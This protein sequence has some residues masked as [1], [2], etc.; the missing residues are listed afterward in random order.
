MDERPA[1]DTGWEMI[2]NEHLELNAGFA[3]DPGTSAYE[4]LHCIC[5]SKY[6][7]TGRLNALFF[8]PDYKPNCTESQAKSKYRDEHNAPLP[9]AAGD[10]ARSCDEQ[11]LDAFFGHQAH[12]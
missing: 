6:V 7:A 4:Q 1:V 5:H 9:G 12:S 3:G 8:S 2:Y 10:L 11:L